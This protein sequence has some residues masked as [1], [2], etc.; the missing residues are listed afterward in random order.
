M[1]YFGRY[2]LS[3]LLVLACQIDIL[4]EKLSFNSLYVI[5]TNYLNFKQKPRGSVYF[6]V[7]GQMYSQLNTGGV[8]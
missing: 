7:S 2:H 4:P 5:G 8:K 3:G 1:N 6:R